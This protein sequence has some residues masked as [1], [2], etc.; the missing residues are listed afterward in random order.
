LIR[1][2]LDVSVEVSC[3]EVVVSVVLV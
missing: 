1:V 3:V 2:V